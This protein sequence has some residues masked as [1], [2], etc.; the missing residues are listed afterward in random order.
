MSKMNQ[1]LGN[2]VKPMMHIEI[3]EEYRSVVDSSIIECTVKTT[4][5]YLSIADNDALSILI[6]DE[7]VVHQLNLK[8]RKVDA[9]TD[10]LSFPG[11]YINPEDGSKYLGDVIICFP[12]AKLQAEERGHTVANELSFLV[13]HG[14]L[15]LLGYDHFE[16]NDKRKME[17]AQRAIFTKLELPLKILD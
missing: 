14:I 10:V 8:Y 13:I 1:I 16:D 15:H 17:A 9:P 11:G 7:Q 2:Q 6:T 3:S 4:L 5:E 12:Q